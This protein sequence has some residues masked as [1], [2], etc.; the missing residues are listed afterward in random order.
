LG[1]RRKERQRPKV[2]E[3]IGRCWSLAGSRIHPT[4]SRRRG[5]QPF[6]QTRKWLYD[7][8][9]KRHSNWQSL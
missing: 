6:K 2:G 1:W 4:T 8:R 7:K 9:L 3:G 5:R